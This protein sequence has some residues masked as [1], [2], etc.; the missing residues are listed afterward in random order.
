M[1]LLPPPPEEQPTPCASCGAI[2]GLVGDHCRACHPARCTGT[3]TVGAKVRR[4]R[5]IG[6]CPRH[7]VAGVRCG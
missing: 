6:A 4:C 5:N 2:G 1:T 3:S 7:G